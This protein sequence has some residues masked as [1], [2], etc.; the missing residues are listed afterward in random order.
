VHLALTVDAAFTTGVVPHT[1]FGVPVAVELGTRMGPRLRP[2]LRLGFERASSGAVDV[3]GP[4]AEFTWTVGFLEACPHRWTFGLLDVTPCLRVEGGAL[5]GV[6]AKITSAH[7]D[8]RPWFSIGA[9][10]R[11]EWALVSGLFLDF[12]GGFRAPLSRTTYF[13]EPDTTIYRAP[14]VGALAAA[15]LGLRFL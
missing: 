10:G 1:L 9:V 15:G 7:D 5:E 8:T 3:G 14:A 13:F 11:A 2:S 12:E 4:T 6:G